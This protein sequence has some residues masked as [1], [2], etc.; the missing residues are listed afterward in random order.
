MTGRTSG[1]FPTLLLRDEGPWFPLVP[2]KTR[3]RRG[4]ARQA[5]LSGAANEIG[6][7]F[8]ETRRPASF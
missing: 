3:N 6:L 1:N 4:K 2:A 7:D 8:F 5:K